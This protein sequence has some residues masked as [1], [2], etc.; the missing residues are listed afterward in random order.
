MSPRTLRIATRKSALA[1]WQAGHVA[2]R[3]RAL[4]PARPVE[5]LPLVTQGDRTL[6]TSLVQAGGKGLFIKELETALADGRADLAVHSMKDVP[7]ALPQGF[8]IAAVLE[9]EDARDA[10]VSRRWPSLTALPPGARVGSSSLRRECQLRHQRPDLKLQ[11]LRGN[12][13]TR[14]RKLERGEYDAVVL[15]VAGLKRLGLAHTISSVLEPEICLPAIAQGTIG[16][17]CRADNRE[18]LD[19]LMPLNHAPTW[20]RTLAE[21]AL[22]RGLSGSCQLPVAGYAELQNGGALRL[23]GCVGPPDGSRLIAGETSGPA[24]R[25]EELGLRL[26]QDLLAR[27][28]ADVLRRVSEA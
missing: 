24:T 27:G 6:D 19:L 15:A 16:I 14:L 21:R 20:Q 25:A 28:A 22:N 18:I 7:V 11:P 17:E 2:E 9:R 4:A 10:F 26:A 23:R 5:L 3:L 13:D 1:L 8:V 12:V